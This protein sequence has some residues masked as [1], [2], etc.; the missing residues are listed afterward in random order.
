MSAVDTMTLGGAAGTNGDQPQPLAAGA[1][2]GNDNDYE[3][4]LSCQ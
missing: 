2:G 1:E 3:E 4:C